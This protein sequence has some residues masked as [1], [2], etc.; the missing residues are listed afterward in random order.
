MPR[1]A[2]GRPA[3]RQKTK[4]Y[5]T[6]LARVPQNLVDQVKDY[7]EIN[8]TSISALIRE[9]LECRLQTGLAHPRLPTFQLIAMHTPWLKRLPS[10]AATHVRPGTAGR[11]DAQRT[12]TVTPR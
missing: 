5:A 3:G 2:T 12:R 9:G 8:D 4:E 10:G 11:S 1:P 6:I 7:A